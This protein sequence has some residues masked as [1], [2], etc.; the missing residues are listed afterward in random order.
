MIDWHSVRL[1]IEFNPLD[2]VLI[3]LLWRIWRTK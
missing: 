2:L 1:M 3:V